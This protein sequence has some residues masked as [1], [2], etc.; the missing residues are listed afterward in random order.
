MVPV[1]GPMV[2]IQISIF[3]TQNHVIEVSSLVASSKP[4]SPSHVLKIGLSC[5][6]V[7]IKVSSHTQGIDAPPVDAP[8]R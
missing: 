1:V 6:Q 5:L 4:L 8:L 2:F 7:H 3:V